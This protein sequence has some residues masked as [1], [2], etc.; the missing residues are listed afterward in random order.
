LKGLP[1]ERDWDELRRRAGRLEARLG[2]PFRKYVSRLRAS[3]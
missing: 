1:P 2:L 3:A